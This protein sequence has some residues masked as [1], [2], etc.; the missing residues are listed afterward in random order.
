MPITTKFLRDICESAEADVPTHPSDAAAQIPDSLSAKN[1]VEV[2]ENDEDSMEDDTM[3]E[4]L[5]SDLPVHPSDA[6]EQIPDRLKEED[7][8][9]MED[10]EEELKDG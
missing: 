10:E 6:G 4:N 5:E 9:D 3:E 7:D 8:E 2:K 1:K